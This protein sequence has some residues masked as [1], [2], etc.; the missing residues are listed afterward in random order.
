MLTDITDERPWLEINQ[1]LLHPG[2]W[3][4]AGVREVSCDAI[5]VKIKVKKQG[6]RSWTWY[7]LIHIVDIG[8]LQ[9]KWPGFPL[10]LLVPELPLIL[11]WQLWQ[12]AWQLS[13]S[14]PRPGSGT[15]RCSPGSSWTTPGRRSSSQCPSLT[16]AWYASVQMCSDIDNLLLKLFHFLLLAH[17]HFCHFPDKLNFVKGDYILALYSHFRGKIKI[18]DLSWRP[19]VDMSV[20]NDYQRVDC[21]K[22]P[23]IVSQKSHWCLLL[24]VLRHDKGEDTINIIFLSDKS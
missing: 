3:T 6:I 2:P 11:L 13:D 19:R 16:R 22:S 14:L 21:A 8:L 20:G 17:T 23:H 9:G 12:L 1:E 10:P 5:K 18:G 24:K 15:R 4:V 7:L